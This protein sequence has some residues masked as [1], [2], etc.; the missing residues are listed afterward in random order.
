LGP[1]TICTVAW[2]QDDIVL[3]QVRKVV[4]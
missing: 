3:L 1:S 4:G 2:R